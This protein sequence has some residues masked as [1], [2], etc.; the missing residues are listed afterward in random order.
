MTLYIQRLKEK[1]PVE[2]IFNQAEPGNVFQIIAPSGQYVL[3]RI[4]RFSRHS[5]GE[6]VWSCTVTKEG[7]VS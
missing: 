6:K 3:V 1:K 7:W 5:E 2:I 4:D